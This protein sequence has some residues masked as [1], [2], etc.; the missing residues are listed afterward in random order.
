MR[1][2]YLD[3]NDLL[4]HVRRRLSQDTPQHTT[5]E[6]IPSKPKQHSLW[7]L[8]SS[9]NLRNVRRKPGISTGNIPICGCSL[10]KELEQHAR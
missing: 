7:K 8:V 6:N 3:E 9:L 4:K 1:N 2:F 5:E 10:R